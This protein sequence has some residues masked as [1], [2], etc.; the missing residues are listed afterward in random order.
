M[1]GRG[2]M[3][4]LIE[5]K[6][7][8]VDIHAAMD[9]GA[10]K[11]EA[12]KLVGLTVRTLQRWEMDIERG[13]GRPDAIRVSSKA[14]SQEEKSEIIRVCNSDLYK[15]MTPNEIVPILAEKGVYIGSESTFY[16]VLKENDLLH[17]RSDTK[18]PTV[19]KA[20]SQLL[21]TGSDQVWS[22]DITCLRTC[23]RGIYFYLYLFMD[24]WSRK[25]TGWSVEP[26]EDGKISADLMTTLCAKYGIKN[27]R[28]HSDNG[29][30]MKCGTMLTTLQ[31]LGV[32]PSF[33]R[34][35]VSNDNPF[36]ESLFKTMK[37][38]SAY[39]KEFATIEDARIWVEH[40][41]AWYNT[42]HHHS[43][44]RYVTP[45]ERHSGD[46]VAI[47]G[48]RKETYRLAQM[49]RPDRWSNGTRNWNHITEV[50]LNRKTEVSDVR[51]CA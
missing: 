48:R 40:F 25:I 6:S 39:P 50:T 47:L 5:R 29:G 43:G 26:C 20:P 24:V 30:P 35:G 2:E 44:I 51:K 22:W 12:C 36:S 18:V 9:Q 28:L 37:Y 31:W 3:T 13:D 14:M 23:I 27:L 46:D 11:D 7:I 8:T 10:R 41:V 33:S 45:Q 17:H 16:R 19:K 49:K 34:P 42:E 38:R 1:G 4:V 15:D 32:A 21:A